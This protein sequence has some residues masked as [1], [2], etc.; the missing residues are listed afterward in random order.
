MDCGEN[1][2]GSLGSTAIISSISAKISDL[3]HRAPS[4]PNELSIV[5]SFLVVQCVC[6]PVH[7]TYKSSCPVSVATYFLT[8]TLCRNA[9][10]YPV[11]R[12]FPMTCAFSMEMSTM[13]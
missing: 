10:V 3:A 9:E 8:V 12:P 5:G 11:S 1:P 7:T 13:W 4:Q 2:T 6:G